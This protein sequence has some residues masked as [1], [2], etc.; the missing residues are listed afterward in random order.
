MKIV[1]FSLMYIFIFKKSPILWIIF[2]FLL[3]FIMFLICHFLEL[4][5][6]NLFWPI[7][8]ISFFQ[9]IRPESGLN[10]MDNI[11]FSKSNFNEIDEKNGWIKKITGNLMFIL[12]SCLG[13]YLFYY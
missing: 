9:F 6:Y 3:S 13:Y 5:F 11:L 7:L 12:G 2:M 4:K 10:L 8:Y 1:G